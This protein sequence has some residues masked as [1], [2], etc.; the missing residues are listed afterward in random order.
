MARAADDI[1]MRIPQ[2]FRRAAHRPDQRRVEGHGVEMPDCLD[3]NPKAQLCGYG[4]GS[5]FHLAAHQV[6]LGL[7]W[8]PDI[9]GEDH[10]AGDHVARIGE[11][12]HLPH[13]AHGIRL[14]AHRDLVH[15]FGDPRHAKPGIDPHRHRR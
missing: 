6:K 5:T 14:M 12:L 15:A 8:R 11:N 2:A 9:D 3:G 10:L 7:L 4:M 1:H 13:R